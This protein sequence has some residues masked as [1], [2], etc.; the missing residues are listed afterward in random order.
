M[1]YLLSLKY[2]YFHIIKTLSLNIPCELITFHLHKFVYNNY[3]K[4]ILNSMKSHHPLI[5]IVKL[6]INL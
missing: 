5:N 4:K 3:L 1:F 6:G 2:F